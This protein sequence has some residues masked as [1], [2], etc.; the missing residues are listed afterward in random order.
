MN[1]HLN[2]SKTDPNDLPHDWNP[3]TCDDRCQHIEFGFDIH[4]DGGPY[5]WLA[6]NDHR[7][8]KFVNPWQVADTADLLN[9]GALRLAIKMIADQDGVPE[10]VAAMM[11]ELMR[12]TGAEV[13]PIKLNE[14]GLD[15]SLAEA[16]RALD[17]NESTDG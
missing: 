14:D 9:P 16:L 12:A 1:D 13:I 17:R 7:F 3:D 8:L 11:A 15:E 4:E 5:G 2:L 6:V 10:S